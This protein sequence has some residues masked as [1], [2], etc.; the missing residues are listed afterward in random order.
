MSTPV[1]PYADDFVL[2]TPL[3]PAAA[4]TLDSGVAAAY[5]SI[6][7]DPLRVALSDT[8]SA[9]VAGPGGR[10]VNPALVLQVAIGQSTVATGRVIANLFYRSVALHRQV[11]LGDTLTTTVTPTAL[12]LTKPGPTVRRA[13][14]LLRMHT[15]D[16]LD[17]TV[18]EFDRLALL[19]CRSPEPLLEAGEIG[20]AENDAP[21][22]RYLPFV[23]D[24]NLDPLPTAMS[25]VLA[26]QDPLAD[27]VSGA[28]ELVRLTQN[29]AAAHRDPARGIN[30]RRLVYGGHTIGLAQA[31]LARVTPGLATVV[32]WRS[33]DHLAPVFEGDVLDVHHS[34]ID[35]RPLR[36][37][38]DLI[39]FRV[40]VVAR[41][42][43]SR[44][45]DQ[46][47][48]DWRPIA[49]VK[50]AGLESGGAV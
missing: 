7:G 34:L 27:T 46:V 49:L 1:A 35:R 28:L 43:E 26:E 29:Q 32:G 47:V 25:G 14:V 16:Q 20:V 23:P 5:Q 36:P 8:A 6:I 31:S 4:L 50:T 22:D 12:A 48:L 44:D 10:V 18:A 37:D 45:S 39:G 41:A 30:G 15:R 9:A 2:G 19:P 40:R 42:D 17:R 3:P 21:L 33:C 24:W 13:K 11:R 38:T